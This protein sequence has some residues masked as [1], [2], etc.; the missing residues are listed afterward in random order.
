MPPPSPTQ[1]MHLLSRPPH[2]PVAHWAIERTVTTEECASRTEVVPAVSAMITST[3]GRRISVPSDMMAENWNLAKCAT[4]TPLTSTATGWENAPQ[5]ATIASVL[6]QSTGSPM[7]TARSGTTVCP[8]LP[9]SSHRPLQIAPPWPLTSPQRFLL[10]NRM[11]EIVIRATGHIAI[12]R[13]F[14]TLQ[15]KSA[16]VMTC[17]TIGVLRGARSI[18]G[19]GS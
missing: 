9:P 17:I 18:I 13:G 19:V 2:R 16:F 5:G 11:L 3:T 4:Q 15:V 1:L 10:S 12:T 14:A 7:T 6:S 8:H